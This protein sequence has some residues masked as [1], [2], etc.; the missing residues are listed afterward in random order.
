MITLPVEGMTCA[1]CAG[2]VERALQKV[3]GVASANVNLAAELVVVD[4][5]PTLLADTV[6]AV[7]RA[8]YQVP[9]ASTALAI[10]GMTCASCSGRVERA[11]KKLPGVLEASVNLATNEALVRHVADPAM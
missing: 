3:A 7:Q 5:P 8:G 1:S 2:R 11:L 9:L 4:A 10:E 6:A